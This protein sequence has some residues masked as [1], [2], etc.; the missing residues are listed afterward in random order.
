VRVNK[1]MNYYELLEVSE[2]ASPEVI[3][4]AYRALAKKY[5][6]DV[7]KGADRQQ[8]MSTVNAAY[9]VLSD[10]VKRAEYD[11]KLAREK[12]T[13]M[14][15]NFRS[16]PERQGSTSIFGKIFHGITNAVESGLKEK[17]NAYL[18][19]LTME[20][21]TLVQSYMASKGFTRLG[22]RKA[23]LDKGLLFV[24]DEGDWHATK[25]CRRYVEMIVK[26]QV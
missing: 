17:Q 18:K 24:N 7:Y 8:V 20:P 15:D 19:G 11:W 2:T 16:H 23:M 13:G 9:S 4:A 22:Y 1:Y 14:G 5:H 25:E 21:L 26:G 12:N 6:P 3:R 10:P